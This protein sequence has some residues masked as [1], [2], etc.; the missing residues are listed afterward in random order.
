M[1]TPLVSLHNGLEIPQLGY[2]VFKIDPAECEERVLQAFEAGYRHIDTASIYGNEEGVGAA[3][4][5]SGLSRDDLWITTKLWNDRRGP[6][7][8]REGLEESLTKLGLDYV[9]LYLIHWPA[10][11]NGPIASTWETMGELER[12]GLTRSIGVSNFDHRFLPSILE[13]GLKPVVDQIEL[14]PQFQQRE[15]TALCAEHDIRIEAWGPLGQGQV[16]YTG[17]PIK[18]VADAHQITWAQTVLAWHLAKGH[19]IFPKSSTPER[20]AENLAASKITLSTDEIAAI[21]SLDRG[22]DGRVSGDP[23]NKN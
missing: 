11:A 8:T 13:T 1:S 6:A 7:Q 20:M 4:K 5:K 23:A 15:T 12:E 2:G 21:D 3:I 14:H 18:D 9:D 10:P 22:L 19:V 16:D 17:G